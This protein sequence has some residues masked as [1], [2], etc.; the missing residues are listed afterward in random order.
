MLKLNS[1]QYLE[2]DNK[3]LFNIPE[4]INKILNDFNEILASETLKGFGEKLNSFSILF[5]S[6]MKQIGDN[7]KKSA[8][9]KERFNKLKNNKGGKT[10]TI[11]EILNERNKQVESYHEVSG[12][13]K[14]LE[15][16]GEESKNLLEKLEY[17]K[18]IS[19]RITKLM[20]YRQKQKKIKKRNKSLVL[21]IRLLK[22]G[23]SLFI[24]ISV[25]LELNKLIFG[26]LETFPY[27]ELI[28]AIIVFVVTSILFEWLISFFERKAYWTLF[29]DI[30]EKLKETIELHNYIRRELDN[31]A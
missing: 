10:E 21:F 30:R 13:I 8:D 15:K 23:I 18:Y 1:K 5:S 12:L 27:S 17:I 7:T 14:E 29:T 22:I 20:N 25:S 9:L 19:K 6:Y 31:I 24:S 11:E 3:G 26:F 28:T 2:I 16:N 4:L